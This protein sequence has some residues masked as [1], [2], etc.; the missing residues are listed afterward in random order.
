MPALLLIRL[1]CLSV[2]QVVAY[3]MKE[4]GWD[5]KKSLDYVRSKRPCVNPNPNFLRQLETYQGILEASSNR[6]KPIFQNCTSATTPEMGFKIPTNPSLRHSARLEAAACLPGPI[7]VSSDTLDQMQEYS[8]DL[9]PNPPNSIDLEAELFVYKTAPNQPSVKLSDAPKDQAAAAST[10]EPP[11]GLTNADSVQSTQASGPI[12]IVVE[13]GNS[14]RTVLATTSQC[15]RH[16]HHDLYEDL[17]PPPA[18]IFSPSAST[19]I[20]RSK[21]SPNYSSSYKRVAVSQPDCFPTGHGQQ[22]RTGDTCLHT[23]ASDSTI[24]AL[25]TCP[26]GEQSSLA[27][28]SG[29]QASYRSSC[30]SLSTM[31]VLIPIL[32]PR[33][34]AVAA[35][36]AA[37]PC[38]APS[39]ASSHGSS[40]SEHDFVVTVGSHPPEG[41]NIVTSEPILRCSRSNSCR[42]AEPEQNG[43]PTPNCA[44][45]SSPPHQPIRCS[46]ELDA[47]S[48]LKPLPHSS[49]YDFDTED[50]C[51]RKRV[52]CK[53][54]PETM[55]IEPSSLAHTAGGET[56]SAACNRSTSLILRVRPDDSWI[57]KTPPA[58][59]DEPPRVAAPVLLPSAA[60]PISDLPH[61]LQEE[62]ASR[63]LSRPMR[64]VVP[65]V[66][67]VLRRRRSPATSVVHQ[68]PSV[69]LLADS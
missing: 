59:E 42:R 40:I 51:H 36:A 27:L 57:Q 39:P 5:L 65:S 67:P 15:L 35:N 20:G 4:K 12:P 31:D 8:T 13:P 21:S 16:W 43:Q 24:S 45:S 1:F 60:H 23:V 58:S 25:T 37:S 41:A 28:L 49:V 6:H 66:E 30:G 32:D 44:L 29:L 38:R 50:F 47:S 2:A 22:P 69:P 53:S 34:L 62:T 52:S 7:T 64:R 61:R 26:P 54:V 46:I 19:S 3:V 11:T 14:K 9:G 55:A 63:E 56:I 68:P 10:L 18:L 48:N 33:Q 17:A